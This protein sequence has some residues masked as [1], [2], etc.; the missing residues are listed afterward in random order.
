M[1]HYLSL[2]GIEVGELMADLV[3]E[4]HGSPSTRQPR[5]GEIVAAADSNRYTFLV[6]LPVPEGLFLRQVQ[7]PVVK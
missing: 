7:N 4:R 1:A 6:Q 2:R 3:G 5:A